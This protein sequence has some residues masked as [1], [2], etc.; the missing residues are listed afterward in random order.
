MS[1]DP[2]L[3]ETVPDKRTAKKLAR[4]LGCEGAHKAPGAEDGGWHPCESPE[5]LKTLVEKGMKGYRAWKTRSEGVKTRVVLTLP[6][7]DEKPGKRKFKK[8]R[9]KKKKKWDNLTERGVSGINTLPSGG[10]TSA[11]HSQ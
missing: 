7:E 1:T 9:I 6:E 10:L 8:R 11:P 5:A 4:T 3:N 2:L